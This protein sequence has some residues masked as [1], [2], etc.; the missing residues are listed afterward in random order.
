M[1]KVKIRVL[2]SLLAK[3]SVTIKMAII[4]RVIQIIGI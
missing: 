1:I 2:Q 4:D 3:K